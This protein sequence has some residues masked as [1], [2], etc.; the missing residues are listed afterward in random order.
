[1]CPFPDQF[2][3]ELIWY[4][5]TPLHSMQYTIG[6]PLLYQG[7]RQISGG[8]EQSF[9][10]DWK[11]TTYQ[12]QTDVFFVLSCLTFVKLK[13]N[14]I[15]STNYFILRGF[16]QKCKHKWPSWNTW[17]YQLPFVTLLTLS[18]KYFFISLTVEPIILFC[19]CK[20]YLLW[21]SGWFLEKTN[22]IGSKS[23]NAMEVRGVLGQV[24]IKTLLTKSIL[25]L[26]FFLNP[27][28]NI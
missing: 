10:H 7:I 24:R 8:S 25:A 18:I 17:G 3:M 2:T 28:S 12:F 1:M 14:W 4:L 9:G 16:V 11:N 19:K 27:T 6:N 13:V 21:R 26:I 5:L 15:V 20:I 22:S 23:C